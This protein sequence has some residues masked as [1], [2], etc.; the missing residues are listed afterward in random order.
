[1]KKKDLEELKNKSIDNLKKYIRDSR[2]DLINK[3]LEQDLSK[4]KNV[5]IASQLKK[6]IARAKTILNIKQ[7]MEKEGTK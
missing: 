5:H 2:K 3:G 7:L 1:M 4:V 6:D